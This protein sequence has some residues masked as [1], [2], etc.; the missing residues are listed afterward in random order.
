MF[1]R[2]SP[3]F[4]VFRRISAYFAV[5]SRISPC[6]AVFRRLLGVYTDR[7]TLTPTLLPFCILPEPKSVGIPDRTD[8]NYSFA[9]IVLH[10]MT[11]HM[12][13]TNVDGNLLIQSKL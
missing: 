5:F 7:L 10:N 3:Y 11:R 13:V 8:A 12:V 6:F 4:G 9:G 2:V 1:R